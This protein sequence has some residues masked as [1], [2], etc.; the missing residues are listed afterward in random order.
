VTRGQRHAL[1]AQMHGMDPAL[2]EQDRDVVE[3]RAVERD[4]IGAAAGFETTDPLAIGEKAAPDHPHT[5]KALNNLAEL[6]RVQGRYAEA[7][8]LYK[9]AL[10]IG[11]KVLGPDHPDVGIYLSNLGGLRV[12]QEDWADAVTLLKRATDIG[13]RASKR[14]SE[15]QTRTGQ[16]ASD[17]RRPSDKLSLFVKA[18]ARLATEQARQEP[19]LAGAMFETAQW[20]LSS[21]AADS[22]AQMAARQAKGDSALSGIVRER[23]DLTGEWQ[24]RDKLLL[25][26]IAQSPDQRNATA[27]QALRDRI[28]KIDARIGE[29]DKTLAEDFPEY[30]AL[31][32]PE[33]LGIAD[34]QAQLQANEVLILF[35]DTV[36]WKPTPE[37]TFLWVV[38]KTSARWLRIELG[39][40][41]LSERVAALRCGL[42]QAAWDDD[43]ARCSRLLNPTGIDASNALPFDL[44]LAHE[45]YTALFA[46]VEDLIKDKHLLVVPSG[47]LTSLPFQVLVTEKPTSSANYADAAWFVRRHAITVLPSASSMK[48]LRQFAKSSKAELRRVRSRLLRRT[49]SV[50]IC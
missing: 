40:R 36:E 26:A 46:Q 50:L 31:A 16:T 19:E 29:I 45:L 22:L 27:E 3:R 41:A 33:P 7:D 34:V 23:Q 38:N 49:K 13:I 43:G 37:E 1:A 2:V 44:G 35:L 20:A 12:S 28:A 21:K 39:T 32:S 9:R 18:A 11:E 48:A 10:V 5:A 17:A 25:A 6:Y 4:E 42:D 30:A 24:A 47:A 14:A 8:G 15:G